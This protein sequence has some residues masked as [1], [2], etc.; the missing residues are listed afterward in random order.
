M[1]LQP[2]HWIMGFYPARKTRSLERRGILIE[3]LQAA[4]SEG[5]EFVEHPSPGYWK[6]GFI[7]RMIGS[8]LLL[9]V[10]LAVTVSVVM[11]FGFRSF[12]ATMLIS[13]YMLFLFAVL[14]LFVGLHAIFVRNYA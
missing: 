6:P 12:W 1:E 2:Y 13:G 5:Y 8:V 3:I 4:L 7:R 10:L 9:F 14:S 11:L